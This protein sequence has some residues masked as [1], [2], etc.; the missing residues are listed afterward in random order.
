MVGG[1]R[2]QDANGIRR[3][4]SDAR[5]TAEADRVGGPDWHPGY[6]FLL[7]KAGVAF[8]VEGQPPTCAARRRHRRECPH[9]W[10]SNTLR[11]ADRVIASR[12]RSDNRGARQ[13]RL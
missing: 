5:S 3:A 8:V 6:A 12:A 10:G 1:E 11:R 7:S 2:E 4:G 13:G 9:T